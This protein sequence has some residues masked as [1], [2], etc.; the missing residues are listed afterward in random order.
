MNEKLIIFESSE[1]AK[2]IQSEKI[3]EPVDNRSLSYYF[4]TG[5]NTDGV[6]LDIDSNIAAIP[7][8]LAYKA[9]PDGGY[10]GDTHGAGAVFLFDLSSGT[11]SQIQ[12]VAASDGSENDY[13]GNAIDLD[14]DLLV[15]GAHKDDPGGVNDSGSAYLFKKS[16]SGLFEQTAKLIPEDSS[17]W[18]NYGH[19]VATANNTVAIGSGSGYVYL[20]SVSESGE[21]SLT[22]KIQRPGDRGGFFWI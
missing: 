20:Y 22:E 19:S 13:F 4:G 11:P 3:V 15:I 7:A 10:D 2:S 12:R 8:I 6:N 1:D 16:S 14:G 17:V 9:L 18:M 21:P 5:I